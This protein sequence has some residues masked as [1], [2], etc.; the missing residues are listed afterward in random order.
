[1]AITI[2]YMAPLCFPKMIQVNYD[3]T[4]ITLI[5]AKSGTDRK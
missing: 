2:S 3:A 5:F 4:L 1:M